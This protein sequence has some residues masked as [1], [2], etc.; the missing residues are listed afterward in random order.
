M[1]QDIVDNSKNMSKAG[2]SEKK[3]DE[4]DGENEVERDSGK[5]DEKD[6]VTKDEK[7]S[8]NIEHKLN[9]IRISDN[10][11]DHQAKRGKKIETP[12]EDIEMKEK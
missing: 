10:T 1:S 2:K 6:D 12:N 8:F 5:D 11:E 7:D 3:E 4:K 9:S